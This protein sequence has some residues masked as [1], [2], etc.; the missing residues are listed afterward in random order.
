MVVARIER[1]G[2]TEIVVAPVT[3]RAPD[4]PADAVELP[5]KVKR[6]LGLDQERSW[7][8]TKELNRFIWRGPDVRDVPGTSSPLYDAI[9]ELLF[10]KVRAGVASHV[11]AGRLKVTTRSE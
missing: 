11:T 8:V 7:I 3:H 1:L 2:R 10:D 4:R 9:P 6:Q 5:G